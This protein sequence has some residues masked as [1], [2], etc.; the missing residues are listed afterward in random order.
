MKSTQNTN[1]ATQQSRFFTL[2]ELL[3]VIAIIAI[4]AAMLL[5]ALNSARER[6]RGISCTSNLKQVG[7]LFQFY[8]NDYNQFAFSHMKY[9][10]I[11][12]MAAVFKEIGYTNEDNPSF[13]RC[14]AMQSSTDYKRTYGVL[15]TALTGSTWYNAPKKQEWGDFAVS[16]YNNGDNGIYALNRIKQPSK[17]PFFADTLIPLNDTA[18]PG[19]GGAYFVLDMRVPG[20]GGVSLNH[21]NGANV[22]YFDGH[23]ERRSE[24]ELAEIGFTYI[25]R[26]GYGVTI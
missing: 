22:G 4:L 9:S 16:N 21:L 12:P 14:A 23:V 10:A 13:M 11:L 17:V 6:A 3:V 19:L 1:T 18:N 5:P 24:R 2:I 15:R 26:D 20:Y 8:A 25:L 7:T